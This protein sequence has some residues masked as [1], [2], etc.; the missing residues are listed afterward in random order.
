MFEMMVL[1]GHWAKAV[2]LPEEVIRAPG[3]AAQILGQELAG[4]SGEIE[5]DG[6]R[7]ENRP[8]RAA[9]AGILAVDRRNAV[10]GGN[11]QEFQLE[12][13]PAAQIDRK[14][15]VGKSCLFKEERDL[16]AVW[17]GPIIE[18]HHRSMSRRPETGSAARFAGQRAPPPAGARLTS[19]RRGF[20]AAAEAP[21]PFSPPRPS[22]RPEFFQKHELR[23][24]A[25]A[26]AKCRIRR[27]EPRA[28]L[29]H[30]QAAAP[31]KYAA[32]AGSKRQAPRA[33]HRD[34][35]RFAGVQPGDSPGWR[36]HRQAN[37]AFRLRFPR[38]AAY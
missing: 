11:R 1:A 15:S 2:N 14:D 38:A 3:S 13:V 21:I 10:V 33:G 35:C 5:E 9:I 25:P 32:R 28:L 22:R 8:R 12:L 20:R 30:R 7:F 19:V 23:S 36:R 4:F 18:I 37:P 17:G 31:R 6:A 26:R 24:G 16:V 29:D 34:E 27:T